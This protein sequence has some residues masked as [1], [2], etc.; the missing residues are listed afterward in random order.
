MPSET[1]IVSL[2]QVRAESS[3]ELSEDS[4][5]RAFTEIHKCDLRFDHDVGLWFEWDGSRWR[6]DHTQKAFDYARQQS[7][8]LSLGQR[9]FG[10]ASVARG[11]E[12][13]AQADR[14]HAVRHD[15]WD[16]DPWKL[17]TPEGTVD[18]RTGIMLPARREDYISMSTAISPEPGEPTRWLE[19]LDEATRSNSELI[20]FFRRWAGYALTG[21]TREQSLLFLFG[22][23]G[24]GK[25]VLLNVLTQILGE[26]A[27]TAS[28][29]TLVASKYDR[30]P[31]E[32]A[33]LRGKR[34][35]TASE[36]EANRE[37][38]EA[39]IKA[40]TGSD[41][42]TARFMRKNPF[43]FRPTFKLMIAGNHAP[44]IRNVDEAMLRRLNI[45]PLDA[46]PARPDKELESKLAREFGQILQW[47][48]EGCLDWQESGL[49]RPEIVSRAT[50]EY[51]AEQ[52]ALG[53]WLA[54]RC[55][56]DSRAP[57]MMEPVSRLLADFTSFTIERGEQ[58]L[59]SK[60]FGA[61]MKRRGFESKTAR[62]NG[63]SPQK[64]Y[65]GIQVR[66]TPRDM[67]Q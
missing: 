10:R 57:R 36:T 59:T 38:A 1:K 24:N 21:D 61:A 62:M 14:E 65:V 41:S 25:S 35:V 50:A 47:A 34:L 48:I 8:G 22:P 55:D 30:H 16:S 15:L 19:F 23:G 32:L 56:V 2:A 46:K 31:V 6:A 33:I 67:P 40:L 39:R 37:F 27:A 9:A 20:Q 29:E 3:A 53:S 17:G 44:R 11:V 64:V 26:Y 49:T 4:I 51:F 43:T 45:V 13:F 18:L 42:I 63:A 52:D 5:A 28:T 7:R 60:S 54:Q 58:P 12:R 66:V